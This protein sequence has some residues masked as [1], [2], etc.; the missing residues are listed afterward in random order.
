MSCAGLIMSALVLSGVAVDNAVRAAE[1]FDDC[2]SLDSRR[3]AGGWLLV[4]GV[5]N[6]ELA[7]LGADPLPCST[8]PTS[9]A[10]RPAIW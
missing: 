8:S 3:P 1:P 7:E 6:D 2:A 4:V 10:V 5:I 9:G